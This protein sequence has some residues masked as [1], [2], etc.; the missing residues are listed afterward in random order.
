[1]R[2][3]DEKPRIELRADDVHDEVDDASRDSFPA[4][5]P[6]GWT[7]LRIGSPPGTQLGPAS[8]ERT[9]AANPPSA[10]R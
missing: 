2:A 10:E 1:M 4:S 8:Q 7:G 5:D 6:P 9:I 3:F